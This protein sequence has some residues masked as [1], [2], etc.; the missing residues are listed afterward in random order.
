MGLTCIESDE[1]LPGC[2]C[3]NGTVRDENGNC[4]PI[5][6]CQYCYMEDGIVLAPGETVPGETICEIW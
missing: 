4:V 1:C 6:N 3:E 2:I 5:D